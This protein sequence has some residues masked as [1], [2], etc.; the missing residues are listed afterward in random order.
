MS[1][2]AEGIA[3]LALS[4]V[5]V[6]A[7]FTTC[8][9]CFDIVVAGKNFSEDYEQLCALLSLQRARFGLWG[10]S[11]GLI[12]NPHDGQR[13]QYDKNLDRPDIKP[14]VERILNNIKSLLDEASQVDARYGPRSPTQSS[15]VSTPRGLDIFRTPFERFKFNIKS[16]QKETS[17][18]NVTRWAIHDSDKFEALI[19]RLREFVD[20]LESITKSLG[21]LDEQHKRLQHEIETI[22]DT[23]SLSLLRDASSRH[24]S[25][26][27]GISDAA[28]QRLITM[29]EWSVKGATMWSA[30][31]TG[32][33]AESFTTARSRPSALTD[34]SSNM[35]H[36][37]GS[38]PEFSMTSS[39]VLKRSRLPVLANQNANRQRRTCK[40]CL[41][42]HYKCTPSTNP[43]FCV[44][45]QET[46]KICSLVSV[47]PSEVLEP[48]PVLTGFVEETASLPITSSQLPQNQRLL[49]LV[50]A[51]P[52]PRLS[53]AAGDTDYG[54]ALAKF[55]T[56]DEE[57]W[58]EESVSY[59]TQAYNGLS[60]AKR[61]FFELRDIREG[62][63]PFVSAAP[64]GDSLT[65]VLACIEGPPETPYE[66][67]VFWITV[68]FLDESLCAPPSMK[69]HTKIYHPNISSRGHI[70]ADY[71]ER[72]A[73]VLS[74]GVFKGPVEDPASLWY[75]KKSTEIRWSLGSLLTALCGLLA[76]PDVDDPLVP[77]I[78]QT[79]LTDY[80]KYWNNAKIYTER[81]AKKSRPKSDELVFSNDTPSIETVA[82]NVEEISR[83]VEFEA[84]L[85]SLQSSL[86][87]VFDVKIP[88]ARRSEKTTSR[89]FTVQR[90]G[91]KDTV[92]AATEQPF[93]RALCRIWNKF[94]MDYGWRRLSPERRDQFEHS[95]ILD[96][97]R[98]RLNLGTIIDFR[99]VMVYYP[100]L[101]LL[102]LESRR[103]THFDD[104]MSALRDM[105]I[106]YFAAI[107]SAMDIQTSSD[108]ASMS[109]KLSAVINKQNLNW[110]FYR[111]WDA[112]ARL[113]RILDMYL[114]DGTHRDCT[115]CESDYN[116]V[117]SDNEP[118][119][120]QGMDIL[121]EH[122]VRHISRVDMRKMLLDPEVVSFFCPVI[123]SG[124]AITFNDGP[125]IRFH[126]SIH[127]D[128]AMSPRLRNH[129]EITIPTTFGRIVRLK[130]YS[131]ALKK[132]CT[133]DTEDDGEQSWCII[134]RN[135]DS[136]ESLFLT[137]LVGVTP[138]SS[139][140]AF[141]DSRVDEYTK[142]QSN[143][144][145]LSKRTLTEETSSSMA[146]PS[147]AITCQPK[148]PKAQ[149]Q[150]SSRLRSRISGSGSQHKAPKNEG[151]IL[152]VTY[153]ARSPGPVRTKTVQWCFR[154]DDRSIYEL[155]LCNLQLLQRLSPFM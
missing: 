101:Q 39:R 120:C 73:S 79:Y 113:H 70:C 148:Q 64:V 40:E 109:F 9:Q 75:T 136:V 67:G 33:T 142:Q 102:V 137:D 154:P 131:L 45:C 128:C 62:K 98:K 84:D 140:S 149:S 155:W 29:T 114:L 5:S 49:R 1:G 146:V 7:L 105:C 43:I 19:G 95:M 26:L 48:D 14:G 106:D 18:W 69:F 12:P 118:S 3:G 38:W 153:T 134:W 15:E 44:R 60:V 97:T 61:M 91:N 88:Q 124:Q 52:R 27:Q 8:I 22:S 11:V 100:I 87:E 103:A 127:L 129:V 13:L 34:S 51:K 25:S 80:N 125:Q 141:N 16:H 56:E 59:L 99:D 74:A 82:P 4:A 143:R 108:E 150:W 78:A 122:I 57:R 30:P 117:V 31:V 94:R 66:G 47:Q 77:E 81:Y 93:W 41:E 152:S 144:L 119:A 89:D 133:L 58:I 121:L 130:K 65:K 92:A 28:S 54:K 50:E 42:E 139:T 37:P 83:H 46:N 138:G 86:R 71:S 32:G 85:V 21:L 111:K 2:A 63:V 72:W 10:E 53:F 23:G 68:N 104:F 107:L 6:A 126:P 116:T 147:H 112:I 20:G 76:T 110:T 35:P 135:G 132:L 151:A 123:V 55:K 36:F 24:G 17:A 115:K 90:D 145:K 96:V